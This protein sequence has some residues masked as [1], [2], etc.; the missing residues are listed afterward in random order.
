M[1][2]YGSGRH[3]S[4]TRRRQV[5]WCWVLDAYAIPRPI[6]AG[7]EGYLDLTLPALAVMA[8]G[9]YLIRDDGAGYELDVWV[10]TA[11]ARYLSRIRLDQISQSVGGPRPCLRC[12]ACGASAGKLYWPQEGHGG[13]GCRRCHALV[14]RSS[15][16]RT[17]SLAQ[18]RARVHRPLPS[19]EAMRR[20][21]ER[22]PA[23]AAAMQAARGGSLG[24]PPASS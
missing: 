5:E 8:Q 2:G 14:Y 7:N 10:G 15:Q 19:L 4:L 21:Q 9:W 16:E 11:T 13:F 6:R 18:L 24:Q 22:L 12:P 23:R 17:L 1:G 20:R 3:R